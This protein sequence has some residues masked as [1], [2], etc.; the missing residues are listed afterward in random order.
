MSKN[1]FGC[2]VFILLAVLGL[3]TVVA[4]Q[5]AGASAG[6]ANAIAKEIRVRSVKLNS[7]I[8]IGE[9]WGSLKAGYFC[10]PYRSLYWRRGQVKIE[11]PE[12]EERL[13][14]IFDS[15]IIS[16]AN[17]L[18]VSANEVK[19]TGNIMNGEAK[20]CSI[21]ASLG[22]PSSVKGKVTFQVEWTISPHDNESAIYTSVTTGIAIERSFNDG[23]AQELFY[24]ALANAAEHI[25]PEDL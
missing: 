9:K 24:Q 1:W 4:A 21:L 16:I 3:K 5:N 13:K 14:P 19:I 18:P 15:S 17:R 10:G 12:M 7:D 2:L 23:G 6:E 11:L 8:Q 25:F 22:D 20:L